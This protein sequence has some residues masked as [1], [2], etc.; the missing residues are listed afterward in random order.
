MRFMIDRTSTTMEKPCEEAFQIVENDEFAEWY[1]DFNT[2]EDLMEF[3][4]NNG[5]IIL[6]EDSIEI[7]DCYRA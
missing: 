6:R 5:P 1:I 7:Y 3:T 2:L 4:K